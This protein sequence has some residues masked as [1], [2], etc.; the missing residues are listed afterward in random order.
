[1]KLWV[2]RL[3][4]RVVQG[5]QAEKPSTALLPQIEP[6]E[7]R[8][9]PNSLYNPLFASA[10]LSLDQLNAP[11]SIVPGD[12]S[13]SGSSDQGDGG[14]DGVRRRRLRGRLRRRHGSVPTAP[15]QLHCRGP[16]RGGLDRQPERQPVRL[17][18]GRGRRL[19]R[20]P[21]RGG[22]RRPGPIGPGGRDARSRRGRGD[23][24][25]RPLHPSDVPRRFPGRAAGP[26]PALAPTPGTAPTVGVGLS[27]SEFNR[28]PF[29]LLSGAT[30]APLTPFVVSAAWPSRPPT[31]A[32]ARPSPTGSGRQQHRLHHDHHRLLRLQRHADTGRRRRPDLR[33]DVF[34]QL[35]RPD[36]P[37]R[38][39]WGGGPRLGRIRL[40]LPRQQ[41]RRRLRLHS[42]RGPDRRRDRLVDADQHGRRLDEHGDD[43]LG[44]QTQYDRTLTNTTSQAT[45]AA[46]GSDSGG[47][48][49]TQS[50]STTG[51]YSRPMT[52]GFGVGTVSGSTNS[53]SGQ[54]TSYQFATQ[55]GRN[56]TGM[57]TQSGTWQD[58]NGGYSGDWYSGSGSYAPA[59]GT[60]SAST[61]ATADAT[62]V[63]SVSGGPYAPGATLTGGG[64]Y[65]ESGAGQH[66]LR[67]Q[68]S[69]LAAKR[70]LLAGVERRRQQQRH[71]LDAGSY[72]GSGGYGY[73]L[74]GGS[75]S[76]T[77][78]QS[79]GAETNYSTTTDSTSNSA[80]WTQTG[81]Y[82]SGDGGGRTTRIR[83][84]AATPSIPPPRRPAAAAGSG[85]VRSG[86]SLPAV[87]ASPVPS[88]RA[89]PAPGATF[90]GTGVVSETE[91]DGSGYARQQHCTRSR[92]DGS[93]Q[94]SAAAPAGPARSGSTPMGIFRLR[95]LRIPHRR[96]V[97]QWH[98]AAERQRRRELQHDHQY[99]QSG[100][101]TRGLCGRQTNGE[102][103]GQFIGYSG[104]GNYTI[105]AT[106]GTASLSGGGTVAESA[107]DDGGYGYATQSTLGG[108]GIWQ[109]PTGSGG[110]T[111][112]ESYQWGYSASGGYTR[113][114]D[115]GALSGTWQASGAA[116]GGYAASTISALNANGSWTTTGVANSSGSGSG[117]WGYPAPAPIVNLPAPATPRAA[118]IPRSAATPRRDYLEGWSS[119]IHGRL[120][121]GS[122]R[123]G[124][125]R[126]HR[127]RLRRRLRQSH[128][129]VQRVLLQLDAD[130]R[131]RRRQRHFLRH[132]CHLGHVTGRSR[133]N[134]NGRRITSSRPARPGRRP[135]ATP[136][137]QPGQRQLLVVQRLQRLRGVG[138][139]QFGIFVRL[140][141][142]LVVQRQ[143][144][145]PLQRPVQLVGAVQPG[146]D[147]V[148]G[149][150][151]GRSRLGQ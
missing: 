134:R 149:R 69:V 45:G 54:G 64:V 136:R 24:S 51:T 114:L 121:A 135:P 22:R 82:A 108:S 98:V 89:D 49:A 61:P 65:A 90:S 106:V 26:A 43:D 4:A 142:R 33:R 133:C 88:T 103:G 119:A 124:N 143:R 25:A 140:G 23:R 147:V 132:E 67:R 115:G 138:R 148:V 91:S 112:T 18:A 105:A 8:E 36:R 34:L 68:R 7:S 44:V 85:C 56:A 55:E 29:P 14:G 27:P 123:P 10:F 21:G 146:G 31:P 73:A 74:D 95:R 151:D 19:L 66:G 131:L 48:V 110:T 120:H 113:P 102:S 60:G 39:R 116:S 3:C 16:G 46:T 109:T 50:S 20:R 145:G 80:G 79:G 35:R 59:S 2:K 137:Q 128:L 75:V 104:D 42:D 28:N 30:V 5:R 84:R 72:S 129:L 40:H 17:G 53:Y 13:N 92:S 101:A 81:T 62:P 141:H 76:G 1:M 6:L 126:H 118:E 71:G 86:P 78:Q 122:D 47:G 87:D 100:S 127:L 96:R 97:G 41:R 139:Q 58:G 111:E 37:G 125:H 150:D 52:I 70:R 38:D 130:R 117:L 12:G 77:W 57:V 93:W 83:D 94:P 11:Y 144:P 15:Q 63:P 32:A 99:S 107:T 9:T